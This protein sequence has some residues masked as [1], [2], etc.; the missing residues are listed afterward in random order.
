MR[1][2]YSQYYQEELTFLRE[3]GKEFAANYPALAHYIAEPGSDPDVERLLEGFAFLTGKIRQKLDDELPELTHTMMG[4]L[5][6]HY[7]RA[8]PSMTIVEFEPQKTLRGTYLIPRI[9]TELDSVP[10][11][12]NTKCR[13]RTCYDVELQP[14]VVDDVSITGQQLRIRFKLLNGVKV[15]DL[16]MD[17]LRINIHGDPV[18]Q[19]SLYMLLCRNIQRIV[20]AAPDTGKELILR[21]S[22]IKPVGFGDDESLI[23]YSPNSFIGYRVLQEYFAFPEKFMFID[24]TGL[25]RLSELGIQETFDFIFH[26]SRKPDET[27]RVNKDNIHTNC[28][29]VV[30]LFSREADPIRIEHNITEYRIRPEGPNSNYYEV[31]SVD[32]VVGLVQGASRKYDYEPFY[33]FRHGISNRDNVYYQTHLRNSIANENTTETYI[34]FVN[35]DQ[36]VVMPPTETASIQLTCINRQL[37]DQLK[38]GDIRIPSSTSPELARFRNITNVSTTIYPSL[39]GS[40]HWKLIAHQSFN[41]MSIADKEALCGILALYNFQQSLDRRIASENERRLDGIVSVHGT[42]KDRIYRG[43][44]IRGTEIQIEMQEDHFAGQGDMYLFASILNEFLSLYANLN[45]FIQLIVKGT[46]YG[47]VYTWQPRIGKQTLL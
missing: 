27:L 30:N 25:Q 16:S 33:S 45:S 6:P 10:L 5:Y 2:S 31:Y 8:I 23:P 32:K 28:T 34:S 41:R 13:F 15:S 39:G 40:L 35:T 47:E 4:L 43:A 20:V 17:K 7:L 3:M 29:P 38:L 36:S 9:K 44:P 22:D 1:R 21:Q 46:N 37:T 24:V 11:L 26:F 18:L 14:I 19:Y 42:Q 12:S